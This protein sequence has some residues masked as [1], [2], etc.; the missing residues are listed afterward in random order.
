[1]PRPH[2]SRCRP[3]RSNRPARIRRVQLRH[4]RVRIAAGIGVWG[5]CGRRE[6]GGARYARH[7]GAARAVHGDADACRDAAAAE[8]GR[9]NQRAP[10]RV[11]PGDK[12]IETAFVEGLDVLSAPAVVG[13]FLVTRSPAT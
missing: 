4:E 8:E 13:K 10:G 2:H 7:V 5:P 1:M 6:I 3:G 12:R 9:E 11:Q